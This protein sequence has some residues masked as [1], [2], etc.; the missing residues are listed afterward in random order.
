MEGTLPQSFYE[1]SITLISKMNKDTH[2]QK[3]LHANHL[4]HLAEKM[5]N[6][7]LA[8]QI[9]QHIKKNIYHDQVGFLPG[10]QG[11]FS[12]CKSL[13]VIQHINRSKHKNHMII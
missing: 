7:T 9:Q 13:N 2:T 6:K 3:E 4:L 11:W 5:F 10:M 1:A 12:V 8:N